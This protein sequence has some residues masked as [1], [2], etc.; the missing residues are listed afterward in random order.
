[1]EKL[2][3]KSCHPCL[4]LGVEGVLS[5]ME[6]TESSDWKELAIS[7]VEQYYLFHVNLMKRILHDL[8]GS[9]EIL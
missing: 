4:I 7:Q 9:C 2:V 6:Y 3:K 5:I 1:M 8:V